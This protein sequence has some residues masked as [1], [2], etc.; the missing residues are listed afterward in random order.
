M[1]Y[2][3][4]YSTTE[5]RSVRRSRRLTDDCTQA[6]VPAI[7]K[8]RDR[9]RSSRINLQTGNAI[10]RGEMS[11]F[12]NNRRNIVFG[13]C[14]CRARRHTESRPRGL[15][16]G[17]GQ[18]RFVERAKGSIARSNLRRFA[19]VARASRFP[20]GRVRVFCWAPPSLRARFRGRVQKGC[21]RDSGASRGTRAVHARGRSQQSARRV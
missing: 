20:S 11:S 4:Y 10:E 3:D 16:V 1:Y 15:G 8:I 2:V 9:C 7:I 14:N 6:L 18:R 17:A 5:G 13:F 12:P 21:A 19:R